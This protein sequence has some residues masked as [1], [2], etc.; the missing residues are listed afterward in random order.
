MTPLHVLLRQYRILQILITGYLAYI[1]WWCMEWMTASPFRELSQW[2]V[3]AI[4]TAFPALV[5]GLFKLVEA[6]I[7]KHESDEDDT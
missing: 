3:A 5:L 2:H 7:K 4:T 1:L 6:I